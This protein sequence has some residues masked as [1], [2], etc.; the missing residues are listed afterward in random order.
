MYAQTVDLAIGYTLPAAMNFTP[1]LTVR[2][3]VFSDL[4]VDGCSNPPVSS[5]RLVTATAFPTPTS[6]VKV[7]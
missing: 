4:S 3:Q 5:T 2:L 6:T 7:T 1:T